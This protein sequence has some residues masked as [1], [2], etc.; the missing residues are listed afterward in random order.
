MP[1]SCSA[2]TYLNINAGARKC[3]VCGTPNAN[4]IDVDAAVDLTDDPTSPEPSFGNGTV[5]SNRSRRRRLGS[6]KKRVGNDI[7]GAGYKSSSDD[8]IEVLDESETKPA[9][10][11][12]Q[13]KV[14]HN[15]KNHSK[16]AQHT[17]TDTI[18]S[19]T[20]GRKK[21]RSISDFYN[22]R[23]NNER[24]P[25][26]ESLME[27]AS[28]ILQSTFKLESLRPLQRTSIQGVLG[29]KS[30]IVIMATGGG[31]SLCYQ[32][33]ALAS[34]NTTIKAKN[35][36][37]TI[38]ICPLIA[39]MID[40]VNNLM[41]KG[42]KTAACWSSSHSAKY[43]AEIMKRLSIEKEKIAKKPGVKSNNSELTP[44]QL[45]YV[46]P[47]LIET[48]RF[49][50]V[51]MKLHNA[52]RLYLFAIDEA[53]CVSSWGH[54]FRPA[55]RKLSWIPETFKDTPIIACTGT[56]TGKVISD[57]RSTLCLGKEVPCQLGSFNRPNIQYKVKY[58]DSLNTEPQG[59]ISDLIMEVKHHH[60]TSEK[61]KQK[62]AGIIYVHKREDCQSLA[63]QI[64]KATGIPT[65]AYHAGLKDAERDET[66]RKWCDGSVKVAVATV[67]FG[68][69][70]DLPHVRY[71][72]HW[73]MSKSLEG[74]YQESGRAGRD[75]LPSESILYYSKDDAS[76][77][78]FLVKK[79]AERIAQKNGHRDGKA[80]QKLDRALLEIE[81]MVDYCIKPGCR[82]QYVLNHFGE[83]IDPRIVCQKTCDYCMDPRKI[84]M[85]IQASEC[86]SAVT[87]S[88]KSWQAFKSNDGT[89]YHHNPAASDESLGD[90]ESDDGF[91]M[92]FDDG[93]LGITSYNGDD[94]L[95]EEPPPKRG[96]FMKASSVLQKYE[97]L[98]C[99]QGQKN[100]FINFKKRTVAEEESEESKMTKKSKPVNIPAH[101]R[102]GM[103]D[104]LAGSYKNQAKSSEKKSSSHYAY[105]AERLKQE[106]EELNRKR[107]AA[108][109]KL[110]LK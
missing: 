9:A 13:V 52:N 96:G 26:M 44:I 62:C 81:G 65:A 29:G 46:T 6:E 33:P 67:A 15:N 50:D 47:E 74:F 41:K 3:Y 54:D 104:P 21:K 89:K 36:K 18:Q 49:R 70:I 8:V 99:Q 77:F 84:E 27:R 7:T 31:K 30:Q 61:M 16:R 102:S 101:L 22:Q 87:N 2:C 98:E 63:A 64:Y 68:M 66:Q 57:I 1:W 14:L 108:K 85:A 73:T 83:K 48:Q 109:A 5:E 25:T 76:K 82:R 43:K 88:Q 100:G 80:A 92:G 12:K 86:A 95:I 60:A 45:L 75:G 35:S 20:N 107:A 79:N 90:Y 55:Y 106:L 72:I 4:N 11:N 19:S 110:G 37:V 58:K 78:M 34:G 103:P 94:E 91:G 71:V 42:I 10:S 59:A 97:T 69:G 40:Q 39:L 93:L 23:S 32:L 28:N 56:A 105:Q 53:H 51:L 38:V 17:S 24:P